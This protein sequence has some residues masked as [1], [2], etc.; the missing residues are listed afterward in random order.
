MSDPTQYL[1][2]LARAAA[3]RRRKPKAALTRSAARAEA[4]WD[5][6]TM[7]AGHERAFRAVYADRLIERGYALPSSFGRSGPKRPRVHPRR[8]IMAPA[9]EFAAHDRA[10]QAA[11]LSWPK[12]MRGLAKRA[13][14]S[15][16]P[17]RPSRA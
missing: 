10:A 14:Q 5:K 12:W 7:P 4:P 1:P 15:E 16:K 3:D 11:G 9:T 17:A 2:A 8:E 6:A 13:T